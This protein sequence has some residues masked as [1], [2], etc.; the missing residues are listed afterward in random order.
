MKLG[1]LR[2]LGAAACFWTTELMGPEAYT[3]Q[4]ALT[5]WLAGESDEAIRGRAAAAYDRY[6]KCGARAALRLCV[7]AWEFLRDAPFGNAELPGLNPAVV[8]TDFAAEAATRR[9]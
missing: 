1:V 5:G 2:W 4:A 7:T 3:L 9:P 8:K 6:Q